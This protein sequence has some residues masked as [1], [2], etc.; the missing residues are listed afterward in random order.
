MFRPPPIASS[1]SASLRG[2]R[3]PAPRR[4]GSHPQT[5][6]HNSGRSPHPPP[7]ASHHEIKL[8]TRNSS[9][10]RIATAPPSLPPRRTLLDP[11]AQR[12]PRPPAPW[13]TAAATPRTRGTTWPSAAARPTCS[14]RWGA[15][16]AS[17]PG[18]LLRVWG[19]VCEGTRGGAAGDRDPAGEQGEVRAGQGDR[20]PARRPHPV[21]Q[22]GVPPQ[23]RLYPP[24]IVRGQRPP[25]R[26]GRHAGGGDF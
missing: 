13:R 10:P 2:P 26:P 25:G 9:A 22:R 5:T 1:A 17:A 7:R 11:R 6:S 20:P 8:A 18:T 21:V 14:T 15:G 16:L 12:R 4:S 23:L 19:E 24:D 3:R